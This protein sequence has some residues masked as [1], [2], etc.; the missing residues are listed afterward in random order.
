VAF[1]DVRTRS[2]Y[3]A[4]ALKVGPIFTGTGGSS[5]VGREVAEALAQG[6]GADGLLQRFQLLVWPDGSPP[7]S[8]PNSPDTAALERAYRVFEK[9][10]KV[11][12]MGAEPVVLRFAPDAQELFDQWRDELEGRLRGDDLARSPAFEAHLAK[13]RSLMPSLALLFHLAELADERTSVSLVS[14]RVSMSNAQ[15]AAAWCEFLELHARKVYSAEL[16]TRRAPSLA[17]ARKIEAGA[18]QHGVN[19]RDL[20]RPQWSGLRTP[21]A[22]TAG[23]EELERLGWLRVVSTATGGRP[24][25]VVHLH[26]ELR[27]GGKP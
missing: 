20:Y 24:E 9:L 13:Y 5:N 11:C 22:V 4:R 17:L 27:A 15:R 3:Q 26:P 18:V 12:H 25:Q 1:T 14:E 16:A 19:V 10:D 8:R 21:E 7:W 6:A 2:L 23:L